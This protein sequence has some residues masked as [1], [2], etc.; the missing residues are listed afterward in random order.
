MRDKVLIKWNND[1]KWFEAIMP[2][3]TIIPKCRD[4]S[5]RD[6]FESTNYKGRLTA[7]IELEVTFDNSND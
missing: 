4:I 5:I 3:G 6:N 2:D 1:K 7:T